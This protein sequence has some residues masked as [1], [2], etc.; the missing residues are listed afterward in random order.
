MGR[1]N[2]QRAPVVFG[3]IVVTLMLAM[4]GCTRVDDATPTPVATATGT[5]Q[6]PTATP[7]PPTVTATPL[8]P[9]PTRTP[10]PPTPTPIPT[11]VPIP[12][13]EVG[14]RL[15]PGEVCAYEDDVESDFVLAVLED[16][17]TSLDGS[18]GTLEN[19]SRIARPGDKLC[20]CGLE[21]EAEGL[22]RTITALPELLPAV[23]LPSFE[24]TRQPYHQACEIGMELLTDEICRFPETYCYFDVS[25]DGVGSFLE[26]KDA[27]EISVRDFD[28]ADLTIGF[29]ASASDERWTISEVSSAGEGIDQPNKTLCAANPLV[30]ELHTAISYREYDAVRR[31]IDAGA[32]VNGRNEYGLPALNTAVVWAQEPAMIKLLIE[33]GADTEIRDYNGSPVIFETPSLYT[34]DLRNHHPQSLELLQALVGGGADIYSLDGQGRTLL[35]YAIWTNHIEIIRYLLD[36]GVDPNERVHGSPA[37][38]VALRNERIGAMSLLIEAGADVNIRYPHGSFVAHSSMGPEISEEMFLLLTDAGL[39]I[40]AIDGWSG[41]PTWWTALQEGAESKLRILLDTGVNPNTC[42][43]NGN[44]ALRQAIEL[45]NAEAVSM[46]IDAGADVNAVDSDGNP[47][48]TV[49]LLK[50]GEDTVRNLLNAGA[51]PNARTVEG[52]P[53]LALALPD[54]R[55]E[56]VLLLVGAGADVNAIDSDGKTMLELARQVAS[57]PIVQYLIQ[58]G[59]E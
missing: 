5:A 26:L 3:L 21:T 7:S 31:L 51:D 33:A 46:L 12:E 18:V 6:P 49:A 42:D 50:E 48:V 9:T 30:T 4:L 28:L 43:S 1:L 14:M 2:K 25:L 8:P 59:A 29:S 45:D 54:G 52:D 53:L 24:R 22:S 56:I 47:L 19:A 39:D 16:G 11:L 17:S 32:D 58:E 57:P 44:A 27:N 34:P 41:Q 37:L 13:C 10:T 23:E 38:E 15:E 20:T 36:S 35:E 40:H 55:V